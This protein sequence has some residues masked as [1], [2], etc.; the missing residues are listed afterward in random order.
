VT[1]GRAYAEAR[2]GISTLKAWENKSASRHILIRC[3]SKRLPAAHPPAQP[4]AAHLSLGDFCARQRRNRRA[5]QWA[6]IIPA[7][8]CPAGWDR[9]FESAFLQQRVSS[10]P[11]RRAGFGE[12]QELVHQPAAH[13]GPVALS[14]ERAQGLLRAGA[15]RRFPV[16][17][18]RAGRLI[19]VAQ[20]W[21]R[22]STESGTA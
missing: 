3:G 12:L 1:G 21:Y 5:S 20:S 15:G 16:H 18:Q 17:S 8:A 9:E 2:G 11:R 19:T 14:A 10:E 6:G 4:A 22:H 13:A 7:L